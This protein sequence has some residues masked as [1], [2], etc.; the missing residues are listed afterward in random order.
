MLFYTYLGGLTPN[1]NVLG[2]LVLKLN[3]SNN[4]SDANNNNKYQIV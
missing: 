4:N 2:R 3:I 1:L